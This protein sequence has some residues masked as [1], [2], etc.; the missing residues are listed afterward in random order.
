MLRIY[1]DGIFDLFHTILTSEILASE[2]KKNGLILLKIFLI[3]YAHDLI[4]ESP[5][6]CAFPLGKNFY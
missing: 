3:I 2:L 5:A 6:I 4:V 1:C